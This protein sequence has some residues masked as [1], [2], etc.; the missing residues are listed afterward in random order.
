MYAML[1]VIFFKSISGV[2]VWWRLGM[3]YLP[4]PPD[5]TET[6]G[7]ATAGRV[8]QEEAT[9]QISITGARIA[10]A[11]FC[12]ERPRWPDQLFIAGILPTD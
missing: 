12:C 5:Y 11:C 6:R 3:I 10:P 8:A 4:L 7:K 2:R 9:G 1:L